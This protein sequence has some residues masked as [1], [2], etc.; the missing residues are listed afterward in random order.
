M[1]KCYICDKEVEDRFLFSHFSFGAHVGKK[2]MRLKCQWVDDENKDI[3][4]CQRCCATTLGTFARS[5]I[6]SM[7]GDPKSIM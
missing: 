2:I 4:I 6:E 1:T 7:S 5:F 3:A